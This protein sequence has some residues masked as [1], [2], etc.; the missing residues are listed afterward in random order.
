MRQLV[1]VPFE[2]GGSIVMEADDA[3]GAIVRSARPSEVVATLG[4]S[5]QAALGR[6]Q[7]MAQA[8]V[9]KFRDLAE[10]P[11]EVCVEFGLKVGVDAG[12]VVAHTSGEANLKVTLRW[13]RP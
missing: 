6:V 8:V 13:R 2:G 4:V 1:E 7:P 3:E 11:E 9:A 10:P 12:L 5:F